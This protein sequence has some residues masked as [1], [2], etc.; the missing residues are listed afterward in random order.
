MDEKLRKIANLLFFILF[1]FLFPSFLPVN[2][3]ILVN[4]V[5]PAASTP[6]VELLNTDQDNNQSL[7]GWTLQNGSGTI[8]KALSGTLPRRGFLTF[9]F[10][11][12]VLSS[13]G[14]CVLVANSNDQTV[15]AVS[16]GSGDCPGSG[17][18][19]TNN[20]PSANES[21]AMI[22][23]SLTL[24]DTPTRGWCNDSTGGCPTIS[25]IVST[26]NAFG[27]STNLNTQLDYSRTSGL[28]FQKSETTDPNG[29]AMGKI[30][31]L[32]E[33][34]FT[35]RDALS[36]MQS[37]DSKLDMSTRARISLDADL[38]RNL[39]TTQAQLTMYGLTLGNPKIQVDGADDTAG[40]AS[41]M[42]YSG[43]TLTFTAA[44]FTVFT[45]VEN[46]SSNVVA[47]ISKKDCVDQRPD[48]TPYLFRIDTTD[49]SAKLFFSP[50]NNAISY[51][52][53]A[54]G[55]SPGDDRFGVIFPKGYYNGVIDYTVNA[56]SPNT[57]YYFKVRAGHG[58]A[59][60]EWSNWLLAKTEGFNINKISV[61]VKGERSEAESEKTEK[62]IPTQA[63][64][65]PR[66]T[67]VVDSIPAPSGQKQQKS[68]LQ[69]I[70]DF[71]FKRR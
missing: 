47:A 26:M 53:I 21:V 49:N 24:D 35:D 37:L 42:T 43:G 6:W 46:T 38:I 60:G 28:Y 57:S 67:S 40:V 61:D 20:N 65:L 55:Y 10:S 58:C 30:T 54:Y 31:F 12:G 5:L 71:F 8:L 25:A 68:W 15:H 63:T 2:A 33:I 56:L 41:G 44:H 48:H 32:A 59:P 16:F 22:N 39:V 62:I 17:E 9:E 23:D 34:N 29:T 14:D 36:W 66:P 70:F 18:P 7:T 11:S 4:E 1:F 51:Y 19:H 50:V 64:A 45:A 27:V 69:N 13:G 52:M 3:S